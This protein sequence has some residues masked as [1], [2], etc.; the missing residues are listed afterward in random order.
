VLWLGT[1]DEFGFNDE[2]LAK[3]SDVD[4]DLVIQTQMLAGATYF[5]GCDSGFA[6]LAGL[7]GIEGLVLFGNSA[8]EHVIAQYPSLQGVSCFAAGGPSRSLKKDDA[9]SLECMARIQVEDILEKSK[10]GAI[11]CT[12]G[13]RKECDSMRARL[14]IAGPGSM[15][16][17]AYL[18]KFYEVSRVLNVPDPGTEYDAVVE[19]RGTSCRVRTKAGIEVSVALTDLE[20]VRRALREVLNQ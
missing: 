12:P 20:N 18:A 7:L 1:K 14:A 16:V 10:L 19:I 3:A 13:Y 8:P 9:R 11:D 15:E 2:G 17:I 4:E 6:H 5:V